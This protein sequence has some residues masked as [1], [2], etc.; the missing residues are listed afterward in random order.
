MDNIYQHADLLRVY[1]AILNAT[2]EIA[3][4]LRSNTRKILKCVIFTIAKKIGTFNSFGD[5]QTDADIFAEQVC[6]KH[7]KK[8]DVI[9]AYLSK[10]SPNVISHSI[11]S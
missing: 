5:E 7:F 8:T 6:I 10:E 3:S 2:Q 1:K 9:R 4:W 11:S